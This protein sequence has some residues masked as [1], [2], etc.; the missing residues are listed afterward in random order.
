[1][2]IFGVCG[3]IALLFAG[4]GIRSSIGDLNTRQFPNIIR[5]DMI[6]ANKD[7]LDGQEKENI[8][9]LINDSKVKEHL[10]IHYEM[11]SKVAGNNN[12]LKISQPLW[13]KTRIKKLY[14]ITSS[15]I[16]VKLVKNSI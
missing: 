5:Y 9:K 8:Q 2:T 6:V 3:S 14:N 16:I 4:L 10:S 11:L 15:S 1:M 12:D 13:S 7:H